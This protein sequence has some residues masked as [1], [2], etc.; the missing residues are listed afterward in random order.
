MSQTFQQD[1]EQKI[2]TI[3]RFV[4]W[5]LAFLIS[6]SLSLPGIIISLQY[7]SD[8]CVT[9]SGNINI[10]LDLWLL[11]ACVFV[12]VYM[13]LILILICIN[14]MNRTLG[15]CWLIIHLFQLG[16]YIIGIYLIINSTLKCKHNSLWQLSVAYC[17]IMG[18][19]WIVETLFI[20]FKCCGIECIKTTN[21]SEKHYY[22]NVDSQNYI[23]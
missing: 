15:I 1:I 5:A 17:A 16:W 3:W 23:N 11:I 18:C 7:S 19:A 14:V 12:I 9:T 22:Q 4:V 6:L 2:D 10:A 20:S 8:D 13:I 21:N